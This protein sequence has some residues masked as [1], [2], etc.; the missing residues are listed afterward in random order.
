MVWLVL[1]HVQ[2]RRPH[3]TLLS[4]FWSPVNSEDIILPLS[5]PHRYCFH[6]KPVSPISLKFLTTLVCLAGAGGLY[7]KSFWEGGEQ[8]RKEE[9]AITD[10]TVA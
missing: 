1:D 6:E 8:D 3:R 9:Q 5:S 7:S 10:D 2:A 4:P